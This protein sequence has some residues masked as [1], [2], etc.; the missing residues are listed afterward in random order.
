MGAQTLEE[1]PAV[2]TAEDV[3][4]AV[5]EDLATAVVPATSSALDDAEDGEKDGNVTTERLAGGN[6]ATCCHRTRTAAGYKLT[7]AHLTERGLIK[8]WG[9]GRRMGAAHAITS[10]WRIEDRIDE[11]LGMLLHVMC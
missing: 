1:V 10:L 8:S 4:V 9:K 7:Y 6:G 2:E 5:P 11:Q 3:A